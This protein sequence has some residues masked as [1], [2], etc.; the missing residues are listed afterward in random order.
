MTKYIF[1][2]Y[3]NPALEPYVEEDYPP[4]DFDYFNR[5]M[6]VDLTDWEYNSFLETENQYNAAVDFMN[7]KQEDYAKELN[8]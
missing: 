6:L 4:S 1:S 3:N 2:P 8:K 7:A 5:N